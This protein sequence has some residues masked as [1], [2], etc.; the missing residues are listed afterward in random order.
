MIAIFLINLPTPIPTKR[1]GVKPRNV[2]AFA[3]EVDVPV[4]GI[5]ADPDGVHLLFVQ[6]DHDVHGTEAGTEVTGASELNRRERI[7]A[8]HVCD[9][10]KVGTGS[11][12]TLKFFGRD[13]QE[14]RHCS[15]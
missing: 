15:R 2:V 6:V 8:A 7:E 13:E 10:R 14:I 12:H 11:S 5:D 3:G 4:W 1:N 9:E